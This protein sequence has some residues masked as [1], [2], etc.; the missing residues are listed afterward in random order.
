MASRYV[1][2]VLVWAA[3]ITNA[4]AAGTLTWIEISPLPRWSGPAAL[5]SGPTVETFRAVQ[6]QDE[7]DVLWRDLLPTRVGPKGD[8]PHVDFNKFTM[9]VAALGTRASAGYEVLFQHGRDDGSTAHISVLEVR[10]GRNCT[11]TTSLTYPI[12]IALIPHTNH[13]IK[14][15]INKANLDCGAS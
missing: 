8:P 4:L 9:I 11:V 7:W 2:A 5:S 14:F 15:E 13:P 3:A 10:P 12:S 1:A 6:T